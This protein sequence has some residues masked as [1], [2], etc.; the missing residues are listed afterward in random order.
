CTHTEAINIHKHTQAK[1]VT[2]QTTQYVHTHTSTYAHTNTYTYCTSLSVEET[3]SVEE[4][5]K[6]LKDSMTEAANNVCGKT[7]GK[8]SRHKETWWWNE[9]V[10][11]AVD[12]KRKK[13]KAFKKSKSEADK[14][15]YNAVK[16]EAKIVICRAKNDACRNFG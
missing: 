9:G 13:F 11:E 10:S 2:I 1:H 12:V 6:C 4:I 16:K 15:A 8:P 14:V 3:A 5:W 7:K